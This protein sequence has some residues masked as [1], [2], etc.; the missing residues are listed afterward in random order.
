[1]IN[2]ADPK[3]DKIRLGLVDLRGRRSI[4]RQTVSGDLLKGAIC[5]TAQKTTVPKS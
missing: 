2:L 4:G 1:M 3:G 5:E